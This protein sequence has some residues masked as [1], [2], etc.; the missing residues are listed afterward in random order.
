MR[1][2][3][4]FIVKN[5][6]GILFII[7]EFF[8]LIILIQ[9]NDYQKASAMNLIQRIDGYFHQK[10][11]RIK[12]YFHLEEE[13]ERLINENLRLR[14]IVANIDYNLL[15]T[16]VELDTSLKNQFDII[17]AKVINNSTNK[18]YNY[19]TLNK[20]RKD[21]IFPDMG[22]VSPDGVVGVV[23]SCSNNFSK[24]L[25]VLNRDYGV[26][27]THKKS[28]AFGPIV[29]EGRNYRVVNLK[30][31]PF[32]IQLNEGDSIVTSEYSSVYPEGIMVG[33]IK[34]FEL[35]GANYFDIKV[36][37]ATDFK[38]LVNVYVIRNNFQ[39]EIKTLESED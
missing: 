28:D 5:H 18:Q 25:S 7:L 27:A 24:V 3:L 11:F 6:F 2:L 38:R 15:K 14:N 31:I 39:E 20:G 35:E 23:K 32:H 33:F 8:A 13:N 16:E 12:K 29:W 17:P 19:I 4:R 37:L 22:V 10:S 1:N 26:T 30:D 21:G 36:E 34:D 9:N